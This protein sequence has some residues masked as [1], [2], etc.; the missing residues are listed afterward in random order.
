[1]TG[2]VPAGVAGRRLVALSPTGA[3][4]HETLHPESFE[5]GVRRRPDV[6]GA[7]AGSGDIGPYYLGADDEMNPVEWI[8]YDLERLLMGATEL[9]IPLLVGSAGG[10]GTK[11]GVD[12]YVDLI[13]GIA[14][15]RKLPRFRLARIY[16]DVSMEDLRRRAETEE[17]R[18]LATKE[19]LTPELVDSATRVVAMMGVEP[20]IEALRR[21]ATVI[22]AGR[23]CD[24]AIFA[25]LPMMQGFP[26]GLCFHLGKT[27][28]C[29]SLVATPSMAK[30]TVLGTITDSFIELEPMYPGQRC[31][32]DSVAGHSLYERAH[33]YRQGV[34]GGVLDTSMTTYEQHTP[35]STRLW[36]SR[37]ISAARYCVKLEGASF[38]GYRALTIGGIRD[39]IAIANLDSILDSIRLQARDRFGQL[40]EG[41]DYNVIFHVYGRDAVMGEREPLATTPGHELGVVT[42]VV[43]VSK[44]IARQLAQY[45]TYRMLFPTYE[46]Q[47]ATA[48]GLAMIADEVLE[49]RADAYRW[50][51]DHLLPLEKPL[52][53]FPVL[54][55]DVSG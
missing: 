6:I 37:L 30:E 44:E 8:R 41:V 51:I 12:Q 53:L 27:L 36:G 14:R 52:E 22:V 23:S 54:V 33:P 31:T 42:E 28:E 47:R 32:P 26:P 2:D 50:V 40:S 19:L 20:Y 1:M 35:R 48:G 21:G 9:G 4:G 3:I 55:E 13:K 18:S 24:D 25:A 15:E 46:G 7:D 45:C 34:P 11:R 39:P 10:T 5:A 49:P 43:A 38:I 17:I 29:A 16:S